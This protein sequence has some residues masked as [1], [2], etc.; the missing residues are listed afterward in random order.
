MSNTTRK[1]TEPDPVDPP[2]ETEPE[3][4]TV[5]VKASLALAGLFDRDQVRTVERTPFIENLINN[6][7]LTVQD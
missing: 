1:N 4:T 2:E 7:K 3:S 5:T 6:G